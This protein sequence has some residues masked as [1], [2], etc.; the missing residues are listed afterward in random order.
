M[1]EIMILLVFCLLIAM[2]A[3]LRN[4]HAARELAEGKLSAERDAGAADRQIVDNLKKDPRLA[5]LIKGALGS[6]NSEAV[7]EFWRDLVESRGLA[8]AAEAAGVTAVD[9]RERGR[10][11]KNFAAKG[12]N[13]DKALRDAAIV[14]SAEKAMAGT[15]PVTPTEISK[16]IQRGFGVQGNEGHR[17]PPIITLTDI[18][19]EFFKSGSAELDPK[20]RQKLMDQAPE[21]LKL[22]KEFDV[23]VIEVVGHTDEKPVGVG[24]GRQSTLDRDLLPVLK[25]EKAIGSA[26]S[27]DNAGLGLARAV[28]VVSVLRQNSQLSEYKILP[29]SGGQL[30]DTDETLAL[31][32]NGGDVAERRR[33][34]IRLRKANPAAVKVLATGAPPNVTVPVPAPKP[35]IP[36]T[37]PLTLAPTLPPP[38]SLVPLS[39]VFVPPD[40]TRIQ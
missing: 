6:D 31:V 5:S 4:E 17:W 30:V 39:P 24:L 1:A 14:A 32:G 2:S 20:F 26:A 29:L 18:K 7:D 23:D 16:A 36:P 40:I 3:F 35:R 21:I 27:V 33:I 38:I 13:T 11:F 22:I 15:A 28:S 12:L 9:L 19:G 10:D 25:N 8:S 34:E 37:A